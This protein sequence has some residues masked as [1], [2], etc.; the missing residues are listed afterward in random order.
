[1]GPRERTITLHDVSLKEIYDKLRAI[2]KEAEEGG[3]LIFTDSF[4]D[5]CA[6]LSTLHHNGMRSPPRRGLQYVSM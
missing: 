2:L 5:F 3:A 6:D 1:M 4:S